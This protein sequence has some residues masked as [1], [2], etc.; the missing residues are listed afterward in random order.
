LGGAIYNAGTL[1]IDASLLSGNPAGMGGGALYNAP[2]ATLFVSNSILA[3][4]YCS[5]TTGL[6]GATYN[7]GTLTLTAS[8]LASNAAWNG[9]GIYNA[10]TL[11]I[12][13]STLAGNAASGQG[14]C[15]AI[16]R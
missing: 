2:G 14:G 12:A 10:G 5:L 4:N 1:T 9:G 7:A 11:M 16:P 3:G 13:A 15:P 8:R 6:G